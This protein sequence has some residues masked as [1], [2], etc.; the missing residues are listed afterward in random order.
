MGQWVAGYPASICRQSH[1][2]VVVEAPAV[3]QNQNANAVVL[4]AAL[5]LQIK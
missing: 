4:V 5:A 2:D 1:M 3:A